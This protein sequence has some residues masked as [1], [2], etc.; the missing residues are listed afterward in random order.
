MRTVAWV[1]GIGRLSAAELH[2]LALA[3][4]AIDTPVDALATVISFET[5]G[6]FNP[7]EPNRAGSG[8][9]GLI[10]FMPS[11]AKSLG[12]TTDALAKMTFTEQLACVTRYF[13]WFRGPLDT[14]EKLYCAVFW[15]AAIHQPDDYV[16]AVAGSA[17]FRQN[18]GFDTRGNRDG[19][20]TRWEIC[21]AVR[22][23]L[24]AAADK[25]RIEIAEPDDAGSPFTNDEKAQILALVAATSSLATEVFRRGSPA[26]DDEVTQPDELLKPSA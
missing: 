13:A 6:T 16:I 12:T 26:P 17:V 22:S 4:D 9:T 18:A 24:A 25:P 20:I 3:A 23:V 1:A 19:K 5:G 7:A 21:H 10:Q 2:A 11:T 15:P 14:V 8:A